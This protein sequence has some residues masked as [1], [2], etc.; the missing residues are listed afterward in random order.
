[1]LLSVWCNCRELLADVS[2]GREGRGDGERDADGRGGG[3]VERDVDGRGGG[4]GERDVDGREGGDGDL[5]GAK[6][7][8]SLPGEEVGGVGGLDGDGVL[9]LDGKIMRPRESVSIVSSISNAPDARAK[10]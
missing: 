6:G 7:S 4:D 10:D 9:A 1:M 8:R 2:E 3:G 5:D